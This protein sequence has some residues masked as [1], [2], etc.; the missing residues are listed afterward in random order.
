MATYVRKVNSPFWSRAAIGIFLACIG[1]AVVIVVFMSVRAAQVYFTHLRLQRDVQPPSVVLTLEINQ[2]KHA[3][4]RVQITPGTKVIPRVQVSDDRDSAPLIG[5]EVD[6]RPYPPDEAITLNDLGIVSVVAWASDAS[7]HTGRSNVMSIEI[8]QVPRRDALAVVS[9]AHLVQRQDKIV[10][11]RGTIFVTSDQFDIRNAAP[12]RFAVHLLDDRKWAV[13]SDKRAVT[14]YGPDLHATL[15]PAGY[16]EIA[17]ERDFSS[18]PLESV[19]AFLAVT[20][21]A[22]DAATA[23]GEEFDFAASSVGFQSDPHAIDRLRAVG[24]P[25]PR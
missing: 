19:P 11:V 8:V 21:W 15:Q 14:L 18:A 5:L 6:G 7:G 1:V 12:A 13:L 16:W 3:G 17:F 22:E 25:I 10:G 23:E 2:Q 4:G 20:G 24:L 9:E